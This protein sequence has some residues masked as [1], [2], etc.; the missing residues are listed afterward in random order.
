MIPTLLT[1][2]EGE[3]D[4]WSIV[5]EKLLDL[6][7]VDLVLISKISVLSMLSLKKLTDNEDFI[8]C[9]Q[10][11]REAGGREDL[12]LVESWVSSA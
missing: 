5:R 3:T 6:D 8:S 9:R 10:S 2:G 7:R 4:E 11:Q 1:W 12:G